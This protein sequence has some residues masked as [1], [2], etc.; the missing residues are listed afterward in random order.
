MPKEKRKKI[1]Q[2]HT[3]L[4]SRIF[5]YL[6][7]LLLLTVIIG[8]RYIW[9]TS[10]EEGMEAPYDIYATKSFTYKDSEKTKS[11][12]EKALDAIKPAL[13]KNDLITNEVLVNLAS[14]LQTITDIKKHIED[15]P[16]FVSKILSKNSR[17]YIF[18][19]NEVTFNQEIYQS[20]ITVIT[21]I[22]ATGLP[23]NVK[24]ADIASATRKLLPNDL[25]NIKK[26][27]I[28]Q[29][30]TAVFFPTK[31]II[32]N[33][34]YSE[35]L[36]QQTKKTQMVALYQ[37][38][39][40]KEDSI[41]LFSSNPKE[42]SEENVLKA[43]DRAAYIFFQLESLSSKNRINKLIIN[44]LPSPLKA[45]IRDISKQEW[46]QIRDQSYAITVDILER[47]ISEDDLQNIDTIISNHMPE[48]IPPV[49]F[50][51][52]SVIIKEVLKPNLVI[53]Q[54]EYD[55]LKSKIVE[56]TDPVF[57]SVPKGGKIIE[58]GQLIT[59]E[60][61]DILKA[62]G[63][64]SSLVRWQGLYDTFS[65][66]FTLIS[67]YFL[68]IF[69]YEKK[70]VRSIPNLWFICTLIIINT[71]ITS[72]LTPH[73][74]QFI[75]IVVFT[76][77]LAL[78]I[79][80][81]IALISALLLCL[82]YYTEFH[83]APIVLLIL[84]AG[85]ITAIGILKGTYQR[86]KI[87]N[88]G[89][90]IGIVQV[91]VYNALTIVGLGQHNSLTTTPENYTIFIESLMWFM[92]GLL[93][94]MV[95]LGLS[96]IIEE[97]FGLVTFS[98]LSELADFNHP[99]LVKLEEKAPGT[100]QHSLVLASLSE[101][102]A[103]KVN[104]DSTLCR[105][106][107]YYHD[108]GKMLKADYYIE[109]VLDGVNP[110]DTLDNPYKSAKIILAHPKAGVYLAKKYNLPQCIVPF[111]TEHHGDSMVSF[112]YVKAK[113]NSDD[114]DKVHESEFRYEGPKPQSK[115]TAILMLADSCEA[116][117]R[118]MKDKNKESI[119]SKIETIVASKI[120][121]NQLSEA[122][123][124]PEETVNIIDSFVNVMM[125]IYHKRIE[126]PSLKK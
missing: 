4:K 29:L 110:H 22:L 15:E 80:G 61:I 50:N 13:T 20:S 40:A 75:P 51:A 11:T 120:N 31:D 34:P 116:A 52:I 6:L 14:L 73:Y 43:L 119:R 90:A 26:E 122:G 93:F 106:G 12:I 32:R 59:E 49:V 83:I 77:M 78:F 97:V 92:S 79:R 24:K 28:T 45:N 55:N 66:V 107:A 27:L 101:Y 56:K 124:A 41:P 114:P 113:Q 91:V 102:A 9:K 70:V 125:E 7:T 72:F 112:F 5:L 76:G 60:D 8:N 109:N 117:V 95:I 87:F 126:Y 68:Y 17:E 21:Q 98:K 38:D 67:L 71:V 105:V 53:N 63:Y 18:S 104:A 16:A 96:P 81:N 64:K 74:E 121:D 123:L 47:G 57:V 86:I 99:L 58:K 108:I 44:T 65:I 84:L 111:I 3:L 36:P 19:T 69:V 42:L 23:E 37:R 118:S 10:I 103:R 1:S 54:E 46:A 94:P 115:E 30:V 85:S 88:T 39:K 33:A 48:N 2:I 89:I 35:T 100:F 25:E 62:E 82:M